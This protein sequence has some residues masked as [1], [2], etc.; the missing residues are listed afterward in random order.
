MAEN[1]LFSQQEKELEDGEYQL[2]ISDMKEYVPADIY[3][4]YFKGLTR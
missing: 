1:G 4:K 3:K 2:E